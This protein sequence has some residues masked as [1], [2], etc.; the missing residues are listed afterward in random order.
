VLTRSQFASGRSC[1][2]PTRSRF[3]VVFLGPR[4]NAELVPKFH[5][6]LQASHAALPMVT[7][8]I[9]PCTNVTLTLGWITL[10]MRDM[11]EGALHREDE[12]TETKKLPGTKM[13]WPT[14]RRSQCNL[15]LNLRHC[16]AN[17][18]PVLSSDR[19]PYIKNK[20]SNCHSNKCAG[21]LFQKGQ[22]TKM[23]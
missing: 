17:Y 20:E 3:F 19:A 13:N 8:K 5:V 16:T 9:S 21:Y 23:N 10:F 14:D 7:L 2:L 12:V 4:A 11:C 1:D 22:D 15:K 6:T 18:R